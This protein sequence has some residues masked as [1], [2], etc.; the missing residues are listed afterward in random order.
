MALP[1]AVTFNEIKYKD[2]FICFQRLAMLTGQ[3]C[4]THDFESTA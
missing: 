1:L 2:C 3:A 4:P